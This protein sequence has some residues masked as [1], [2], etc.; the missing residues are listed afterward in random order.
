MRTGGGEGSKA[1]HW[2]KPLEKISEEAQQREIR[3]SLQLSYLHE[4]FIPSTINF[5][6]FSSL[7]ITEFSKFFEP[8]NMTYSR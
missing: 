6:I 4:H 5:L 1:T 7:A 8:P 2:Q 3:V